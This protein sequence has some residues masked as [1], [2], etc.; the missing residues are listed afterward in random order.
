VPSEHTRYNTTKCGVEEK[1]ETETYFL[2]LSLLDPRDRLDGGA[3]RW[4]RY[5]NFGL[6]DDSLNNR[7]TETMAR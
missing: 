2:V 1:V 5:A 3:G 6:M 7:T 4:I